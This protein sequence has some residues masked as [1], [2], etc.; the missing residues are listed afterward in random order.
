MS[1]L[2]SASGLVL[3][4]GIS[5]FGAEANTLPKSSENVVP[6]NLESLW[7]G[8]DPRAEPLEVKTIKEWE[9]DNVTLRIVRLRIGVFKGVKATLAA[10]YGFP[11]GATKLPGLVQVHGGG[12]YADYKACLMNGKRGYATV[13]VAWAGRISAPEYRVGPNEVKLFWDGKI[14]APNYRLTTDWGAVDGYHAPSRNSGNQFPSA[15]SASWTIDSVE[16]PRNSG[17][18]LNAI[19]VRR[20]LTFLEKQPEVNARRLGVYGHSMGGKLT[21]LAAID[22]RVKA[23]APSC[24]GISDRDNA[25]EVFRN[26]LGDNVSLQDITCPIVFLSPA[27]D[28]HGRI[29][30]LPTVVNEIKSK[31]WRVTCSPHHNHQDTAPYEVATLLWFDEHLKNTFEMPRTPSTELLLTT[32]DGIPSITIHPDTSKSVT[33]IDIYYTQDG[34]L[35]ETN[36]DRE[37]TVHRFWHHAKS[38][39]SGRHWVAKLPLS[40]TDRPLW[41]YANV[42]YALSPGVQGAGYYYRIY[43]ANSFNL[44]SLLKTVTPEELQTAN[45]RATL[46]RST[47]I[48]DFQG[49]WQKEWFT[50]KPDDWALTTNKLYADIYKAPSDAKLV[51]EVKSKQTNKLVIQVDGYAAE[52]PLKSGDQSQL[53]SL[54]PSDFLNGSGEVLS[55]WSEVKQLTLTAAARLRPQ[56]DDLGQSRVVGGNW[57]GDPPQFRNLR[58]ESVGASKSSDEVIR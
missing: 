24:G 28:F 40:S 9:E 50:Y 3:I 37:N 44:S 54:I 10:V 35:H 32:D 18:F 11:S 53:I 38:Q 56:R 17:W 6:N 1:S 39:K 5:A 13:S 4:L 25:S 57:K 45:V 47:L 41:V 14:D 16:S 48:E 31:H 21:V 23:A 12:Q 2:A 22:P 58:W 26:T 36:A 34:K 29:S 43:E 20:A 27:N 8:F 49:D 46:R 52:V 42:S 30:D 55:D 51:L 19:A 15:K 7:S 33:S